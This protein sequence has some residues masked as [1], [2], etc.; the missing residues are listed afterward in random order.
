MINGEE[1]ARLLKDQFIKTRRLTEVLQLVNG[2]SRQYVHEL[3]RATEHRAARRR[4]RVMS[5]PARSTRPAAKRA[6]R[7][8][9]EMATVYCYCRRGFYGEMIQCDNCDTWFHFGCVGVTE[10]PGVNERWMCP[11]CNQ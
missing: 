9:S 7:T 8:L 2:Y 1:I 11:E 4:R 6:R 5:E 3:R 10:A